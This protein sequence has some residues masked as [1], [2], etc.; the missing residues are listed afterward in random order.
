MLAAETQMG[1]AI[2]RQP[3]E[4][5]RVIS[6]EN[7]NIIGAASAIRN[8]KRV[9]LVGTGSSLYSAMFGRYFFQKFSSQRSIFVQS[10]YEFSNYGAELELNKDDVVV[11]ISHRGYK[12]YSYLSLKRAKNAFSTTIAI[13][14]KGTSIKEDEADFILYT[15]DQEKSSAHTVSL[16]SSM[17]ILLALSIMSSGKP[18]L[19]CL[20]DLKEIGTKLSNSM[21]DAIKSS[22]KN[23]STFL[24]SFQKFGTLWISGSGTNSVSAM[25][26]S[27]KFQETS[28]IRAY[29]YEIEQLIHGPLRS[30]NLGTDI[31]ISISNSEVIER[32]QE[33]SFAIR[34]IGGKVFEICEQGTNNCDFSYG[35]NGLP[36][37]LSCFP[38]L[39]ILQV[40]ALNL[41]MKLGTDPDGF[42]KEDPSFEKLD[43]ILGL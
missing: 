18:A 43:R 13:T 2:L 8:A 19:Q 34:D 42:R 32:S 10:S 41:A 23:A 26:A 6:N 16:T 22:F 15:V 24:K 14:G 21:N 7:Q 37:V 17:A 5:L 3:S 35:M 4:I 28:Y 38:A 39:C 20:S 33:L 31:F 40:L 27:L 25:E 36:E 29:G 9:F 12:R 11:I 30:A 1:K